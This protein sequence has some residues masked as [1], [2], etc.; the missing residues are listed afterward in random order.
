MTK[1]GD[2]DHYTRVR[3]YEDIL[4]ALPGADHAR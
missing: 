4:S 2:V 3:C 1:P